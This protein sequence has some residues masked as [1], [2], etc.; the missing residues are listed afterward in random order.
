MV[1]PLGKHVVVGCEV[2]G[3]VELWVWWPAVVWEA[4][5]TVVMLFS[6]TYVCTH[7]PQ[8][9]VLSSES[10]NIHP[11]CAALY[12]FRTHGRGTPRLLLEEEA[13]AELRY[14]SRS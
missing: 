1:L 6:N 5:S 7:P 14:I 4:P 9:E 2:P 3:A 11:T 10:I 8:V 13:C 12:P